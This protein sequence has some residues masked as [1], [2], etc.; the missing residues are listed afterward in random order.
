MTEVYVVRANSSVVGVFSS[1]RQA[2]RV[3]DRIIA[4]FPARMWYP[5]PLREPRQLSGPISSI[6]V[7]TYQMNEGEVIE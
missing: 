7:E 3:M 6:A 4:A 1:K 5:P 2:Q